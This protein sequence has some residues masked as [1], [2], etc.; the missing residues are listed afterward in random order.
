MQKN[1]DG[2]N[3][4]KKI[5]RGLGFSDLYVLKY[6]KNPMASY[7]SIC[8][9]AKYV[10][11]LNFKHNVERRVFRWEHESLLG[12]EAETERRSTSFKETN[13]KERK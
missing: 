9:T 4:N 8:F 12:N 3:R 6:A 7:I 5:I 2:T 10:R 13:T 11:I 1:W